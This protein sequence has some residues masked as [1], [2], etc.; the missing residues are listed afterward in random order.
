MRR[1]YRKPLAM[2]IRPSQPRHGRGGSLEKPGFQA[3]SLERDGAACGV[4]KGGD[5]LPILQGSGSP[6]APWLVPP[7]PR[8]LPGAADSRP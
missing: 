5:P 1:D 6:H 7:T 4:K 3:P 8:L 2:R